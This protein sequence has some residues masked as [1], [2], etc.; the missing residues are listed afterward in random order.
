MVSWDKFRAAKITRTTFG[1]SRRNRTGSDLFGW[2]NTAFER[3]VVPEDQHEDS[4]E[5]REERDGQ[6]P[7]GEPAGRVLP[8]RTVYEPSLVF[9]LYQKGRDSMGRAAPG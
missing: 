5:E 9:L 2:R 4:G 1:T 6:Q 7:G 8:P 3:R